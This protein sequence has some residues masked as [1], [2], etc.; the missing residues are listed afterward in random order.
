MLAGAHLIVLA[1]A[2]ALP[3]FAGEKP[4]CRGQGASY[5]PDGKGLLLE[6]VIDHR[7]RIAILDR[8]RRKVTW[9]YRGPGQACQPAWGP[10]GSVVFTAGHE[11]KT[12]FAASAEGVDTGYNLYVWR[13]GV[14][15]QVTF[16]RI[17]AYSASFAPDGRRIYFATEAVRPDHGSTD[18]Y[19]NNRTGL[20][21]VPVSDG[22]PFERV[23]VMSDSNTG[24]S[25]PEVS[26][27][28][29]DLLRC[30]VSGYGF[31]WQVV[32]SPLASPDEKRFLTGR[33]MIAC[34]PTWSPDGRTVAFAAC[35]P[36]DDGWQVYFVRPDGTGLR[37]IAAGNNPAFSP[38]GRLLA[39]DRDGVV[40]EREVDE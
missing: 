19:S 23:A 30:E 22:G 20:A 25:D 9:V 15:R 14:V 13:T 8:D 5:S 29:R 12:A 3:A 18:V 10:D 2:A 39:Y 40:Y 7:H 35:G 38:D 11:T 1:A 31:P 37:R 33:D 28:G 34:E 4:L 6:R 27:D 24:M 16:G 26:P 21:V 36:Q 17:R 32:V